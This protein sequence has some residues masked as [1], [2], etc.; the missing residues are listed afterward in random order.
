MAF[1]SRTENRFLNTENLVI[2]TTNASF[3][4]IMAVGT[5]A[6]IVLAGIDLSIGS[7]YAMA[8][9]VGAMLLSRLNSGAGD[10]GLGV[11]MAVPILL[12]TEQWGQ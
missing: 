4:A 3:I 10:Q 11:W 8:A 12:L 9:I 7:I 2:V 5:T 6:I 1:G